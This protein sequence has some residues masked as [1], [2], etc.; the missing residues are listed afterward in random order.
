[1]L[2][3]MLCGCREEMLET[4]VVGQSVKVCAILPQTKVSYDED[5]VSHNLKG[6]W[7][8]GDVIFG[9][10]EGGSAV[11]FKVGSIDPDTGT[12]YL[13]QT[14][15][16]SLS[17]GDRMYGIYCPGMGV[18]D[19]DGNSLRVDFSYQ[20]AGSLKVL[21][22]AESEVSPEG[23]VTLSFRN[24]VSVIGIVNPEV[25][26]SSSRSATKAIVSGHKL[27][28]SGVVS[29]IDGALS[30]TP[31]VPT[32]FITKEIDAD[33]A[34][35]TV[36]EPIYVVVPPCEVDKV[37]LCAGAFFYSWTAGRSVGVSKYCRAEGK[38]FRPLSG[39]PVA[40]GIE[41]SGTQWSTANFNI[42]KSDERG[43]AVKWAD[44]KLI[45]SSKKIS[46]K[47]FTPLPGYESGFVNMAGEAYY[48][49]TGFDK[50]NATDGRTVLDPVDDIVQLTYPG[51]GWRMPTK[52]EWEALIGAV[53][54]GDI[55][56]TFVSAATTFSTPG[57]SAEFTRSFQ[58]GK[59]VNVDQGPKYWT[60]TLDSAAP[61]KACYY[62]ISSSAAPKA[63]SGSRALGLAVRPVRSTGTSTGTYPAE[64]E[65]P[66]YNAGKSILSFP[67]W[68]AISVDYTNL[69]AGNHPRLLLNRNDFNGIVNAVASGSNPYLVKLHNQVI[70]AA[71]AAAKESNF[72]KPLEYE[73][74]ASGRRLL[75]VSRKALRKISSLAYAYRCTEDDK[76]L[77]MAEFMIKTV[78]E[79][80]DW[81]PSHFLD[82]AEMATGVALGLDWLY[83][84]LSDEVRSLAQN[85]LENYAM[86]AALAQGILTTSGNW[87]QVCCGGITCAALATYET[88]PALADEVVRVCLSSNARE[89]NA[90]YAPY[91]A[92]P[93]GSGYW[94]Y[95]TCFQGILNLALDSVLGTDFELS[96][97]CGFDYAG[98]YYDYI[99]DNAGHRFNYSDSGDKDEASYGMWYM[100]YIMN[101][102]QYLYHDLPYLDTTYYGD[103]DYTFLAITCAYRMGAVT[104]TPPAGRLY[105]SEGAN[106][107]LICRTGWDRGDLYLALKA[108]CATCGHSHLDMGEIVFESDGTRW[109]KDFVYSTSYAEVENIWK[110]M[111]FTGSE[112]TGYSEGSWRWKLFQYH[113]RQ[114]STLT[115]NDHDQY[116]YGSGA[117]YETFDSADKL[118]GSADLSH[119][120]SK[121]LE[122][123][124]RTAL[125]RGGAY[126]EVTDR[127]KTGSGSATTHVRWTCCSDAVPEIVE[128]G[129]RL[130]NGHTDML[131]STDAPSPEFHIW[132]SDPADY[133]SEVI[134]KQNPLDGYIC[135]FEFDIPAGTTSVIV[136]TLKEI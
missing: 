89:G 119:A 29:V 55:E 114:H 47:T 65:L 43:D 7:E 11:S 6:S 104:A 71:D 86:R 36:G 74:D 115:I 134:G 130:S 46:A 57:A 94:E 111:G 93:E 63:S 18:G 98:E 107:I 39:V 109:F 116:P 66:N 51:T 13:D 37:T 56:G 113:N 44:S 35:G 110:G 54:A 76:Y 40:S 4:P 124:T 42:S 123:A 70:L 129:I 131:L 23:V 120:Y 100:A 21:M 15:S 84:E 3:C 135:G 1:M 97:I 12:A 52:P 27:V 83:D 59:G 136:T 96:K 17:E 85:R 33:I 108:G 62:S 28:S 8:I 90:I 31:D 22:F 103:E 122:D 34:S 82:V 117:I 16:V 26:T 30:W 2:S 99:R 88:C 78:C 91:G 64:E 112:Q 48:N 81:H 68:T 73:L 10:I 69:T 92:C 80:P 38:D 79:Y 128:G 50:Y 5:G 126:L 127:L 32:K 25:A 102:P 125:I 14:T 106:P 95:G 72:S 118:G 49:G 60:S 87:N 53:T 61:T 67:D 133:P 75:Q 9:F 121:D 77:R 101:R 24:A 19:L 105:S 20:S 58:G 132:S 41:V 45:Y